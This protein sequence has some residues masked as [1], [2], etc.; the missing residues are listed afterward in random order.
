[1]ESQKVD[2][3]NL[4][5]SKARVGSAIDYLTILFAL[6]LLSGVFIDGYAH[7]HIDETLET[8]FT[9][10]HAVLYSGFLACAIWF[11]SL[12]YRN[13]RLGWRGR[14]A[15]P[16]GYGTGVIGVMIFAVGGLS[17]MIWHIILGI[18]VGI[19]ALYSP[20]HLLLF[21]GGTLIVAS[22]LK[23]AWVSQT[24]E[25]GT[26]PR[27]MQLLPALVSLGFATSFT[28]FFAMNYW[29]FSHGYPSQGYNDWLMGRGLQHYMYEQG[30]VIGI[31]NILITNAI[32]II[33]IVWLLK[34]WNPPTGSFTL[35]MTIPMVFMSV[36]EGFDNYYMIAGGIIAGL[37]ADI[38]W[39]ALQVSRG[40]WRVQLHLGLL[41]TLIWILYFLIIELQDKV[42]WEPEYWGGAIV[43]AVLCSVVFSKLSRT[44]PEV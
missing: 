1:M 2:V 14:E 10:W 44:E 25:G 17:D 6:W 38:L 7:G 41:S 4:T 42:A 36:L 34:R 20:S 8:F 11:T 22:P 18:E 19:E 37:I 9:P 12:T 30:R 15:I 43:L 3:S 21:L 32:L 33:P 13:Y 29:A 27:L 39:R 24:A 23:R 5:R 26:S 40:G 28:A 31:A 16:H 35:L